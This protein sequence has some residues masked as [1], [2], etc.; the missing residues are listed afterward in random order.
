MANWWTHEYCLAP[1][2][3]LKQ[4][5]QE[6]YS[7]G[8]RS[9]SALHA[10][11]T[12]LTRS[13]LRLKDLQGEGYVILDLDR[14]CSEFHVDQPQWDAIRLCEHCTR[15]LDV[16]LVVSSGDTHDATPGMGANVMPDANHRLDAA[17]FRSDPGLPGSTA[18]RSGG[19]GHNRSFG[20]AFGPM[21]GD[22]MGGG[23]TTGAGGGGGLGDAHAHVNDMAD[24]NILLV[25][26]EET[27]T[28]PL[29]PQ[30][31]T[32][33]KFVEFTQSA[34]DAVPSTTH[35]MLAPGSL[36][37]GASTS[38]TAE[39]S[40]QS[41]A[42]TAA[43]ASATDAKPRQRSKR[44]GPAEFYMHQGAAL[45]CG[46]SASIAANHQVRMALTSHSL[47]TT[48][49]FLESVLGIQTVHRQA[50]RN[51]M[52]KYDV[53]NWLNEHRK[54]QRG[55]SGG[56]MLRGDI[57]D[58]P[59]FRGLPQMGAGYTADFLA[60][61]QVAATG[62]FMAD[63][64]NPPQNQQQPQ[65]QQHQQQHN[66]ALHHA[67]DAIHA[68]PLYGHG[69]EVNHTAAAMGGNGHSTHSTHPTPGAVQNLLQQHSVAENSAQFG[70]LGRPQHQH[71]VSMP[72]YQ[73]G[74]QSATQQQLLPQHPV[75]HQLQQAYGGMYPQP[76]Y[77][78][79]A[80]QFP[81]SHNQ[82]HSQ[83]MGLQAYATADAYSQQLE[84]FA[85]QAPALDA[86][87]MYRA[88]AAGNG[89]QYTSAGIPA[90]QFADHIPVNMQAVALG[91]QSYASPE[92]HQPQHQHQGLGA[93]SGTGGSLG[94]HYS[95]LSYA[96][97]QS[98]ATTTFAAD[99]H[100]TQHHAH[101]TT[102]HGAGVSAFLES[103]GIPAEGDGVMGQLTSSVGAQAAVD[104]AST[105]TQSVPATTAA[106]SASAMQ[107]DSLAG[108]TEQ[109]G[110]AGAGDLQLASGKRKEREEAS[111]R[112]WAS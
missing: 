24:P 27:S 63:T 40:M 60:L 98:T 7:R 23:R 90:G 70:G 71:A 56:G 11:L 20:A 48:T 3:A 5:L 26:D 102:T 104:Q 32:A 62:N 83:A 66:L 110:T 17:Y 80:L 33:G 107:S 84:P 37:A 64:F 95:G 41:E 8:V 111:D 99:P 74:H 85:P 97:L 88:G 35:D 2:P 81:P 9:A 36:D 38:L 100:Q 65:H 49:T 21:A 57:D 4:H 75:P 39:D 87:L 45:E 6:L 43:S 109:G 1:H 10:Q 94:Q 112:E 34:P 18:A 106:A 93:F 51:S 47:D 46:C 61:S 105:V 59:Q 69:G 89:P 44:K 78:M 76:S 82:Q 79:S 103:S 25:P 54:R 12:E 96:A 108:I 15:V 13:E 16:P 77:A 92:L 19:G 72:L 91:Y 14:L 73:Q 30:G 101:T 29:P 55:S 31:E 22:S 58:S 67:G 42:S 50:F 68:P 86:G 53:T 52:T 28:A